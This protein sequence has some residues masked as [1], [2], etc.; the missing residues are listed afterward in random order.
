VHMVSIRS[1][2]ENREVD[3][4]CSAGLV[5]RFHSAQSA[6]EELTKG[7]DEVRVGINP[8]GYVCV[9]PF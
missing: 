4:H 8:D 5:S 9:G 1:H 6:M 3:R 7:S 2:V